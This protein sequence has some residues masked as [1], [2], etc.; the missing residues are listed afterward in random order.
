MRINDLAILL[1]C[2]ASL[3]DPQLVVRHPAARDSKLLSSYFAHAEAL[4][5]FSF[6]SGKCL[7][8]CFVATL[9]YLGAYHGD[10]L[11]PFRE[12]ISRADVA[13]NR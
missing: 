13:S 7:E 2:K 8:A 6:G 12:G 5:Y 1:Q 11:F 9:K 4:S 10:T 3:S